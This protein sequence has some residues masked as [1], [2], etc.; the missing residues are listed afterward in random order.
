ML[1]SARQSKKKKS[2]RKH[3]S[4]RL[5]RS[6]KP[7]QGKT[8]TAKKKARERAKKKTTRAKAKTTRE[9]GKVTFRPPGFLGLGGVFRIDLA[10]HAVAAVALGGIEAAVGALDQRIGVVDRP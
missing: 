5:P 6:A 4:F 3:L 9:N 7:T 2:V 8:S 10:D 1:R